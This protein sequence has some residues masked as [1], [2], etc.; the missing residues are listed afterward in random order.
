MNESEGACGAWSPGHQPCVWLESG[1]EP[2][3][4][5][6]V[7]TAVW[8]EDGRVGLAPSS[9][10][11]R[12]ERTKLGSVPRAHL[13][14]SS[15]FRSPFLHAFGSSLAAGMDVTAG[16]GG[17]CAGMGGGARAELAHKRSREL[18]LPRPGGPL[19]CAPVLRP[20]PATCGSG[21]RGPA[22]PRAAPAAAGGL[23]ARARSRAGGRGSGAGG[24]KAGMRRQGAGSGRSGASEIGSI[25]LGIPRPSAAGEEAGGEGLAGG[26]GPG[27][28]GGGG[29]AGRAARKKIRERKNKKKKKKMRG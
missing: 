2:G 4:S 16:T 24:E 27:A 10:K 8:M 14:S 1:T 18:R 26:G 3:R 7:L 5:G 25:V 12:T 13:R 9:G 23:H 29:P 17:A 22:R 21:G 6:P 28:A 20:A 19:A 11:W 15:P